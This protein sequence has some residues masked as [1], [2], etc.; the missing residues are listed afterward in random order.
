MREHL[1]IV[2]ALPSR[3][4]PEELTKSVAAEDEN[5]TFANAD[6][7]EPREAALNER[8]TDPGATR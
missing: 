6:P 8:L 3:W 7:A 2:P 5:M 1:D 4:A